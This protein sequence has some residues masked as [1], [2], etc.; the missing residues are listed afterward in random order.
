MWTVF[1]II[2]KNSREDFCVRKKTDG[3]TL[4]KIA[5]TYGV[6]VSTVS[7]TVARA[8]KILF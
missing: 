2:G 5:E 3:Q 1:G 6:N 4:A 8:E 7:R